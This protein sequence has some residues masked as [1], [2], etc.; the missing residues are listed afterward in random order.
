MSDE[1]IKPRLI[2]V[3]FSADSPNGVTE[4]HGIAK[5]SFAGIIFE[6][7]SKILG[8]VSGEVREVRVALEEILDIRFRKGFYKFFSRIHLRLKN[9]QK[10]SE[11]P[12]SGGK[13][14]LKIKR[15]DFELA[16]E[17]VAQTLRLL[18]GDLPPEL[19]TTDDAD[20]QLPPPP[21]SVN[22]LFDTEKLKTKDL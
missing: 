20:R 14:K 5:F 16:R 3:P 9:Y 12:N 17:A 8:L 22:E 19:E 13:I 21:T 7:E 15:E 4:Y 18:G 10:V 6:F 11:L 2:T 1:N